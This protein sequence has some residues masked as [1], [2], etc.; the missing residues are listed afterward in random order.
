MAT[1]DELVELTPEQRRAWNRF[2][3]AFKD[4]KKAGGKFYTSLESV[5]GYNG[6]HVQD[7]GNEGD[8][9]LH[10]H[11]MPVFIFDAGLAGFADDEHFV[12]FK[13]GVEIDD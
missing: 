8:H 13:D 12:T 3:K 4:F 10:E 11:S 2:E 6:E 7:I 5:H 1:F 9:S